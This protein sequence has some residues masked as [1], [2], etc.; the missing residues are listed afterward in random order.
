MLNSNQIVCPPDLLA[1]AKTLPPATGVI[2][3]ADNRLTLESVRMAVDEGLLV[4]ILVGAPKRIAAT[5]E[6]MAWDISSFRMVAAE[7]DA[8]VANR[9][10]ELAGHGESELLVKGHVHTDAF[11]MGII[12]RD[13]G[14]RV[15]RRLTHVFHM[16]VPGHGR[17]LMIADGAVNVAPSVGARME[18]MANA[19][20]LAHAL[21]IERPHVGVLSGTEEVT[22]KM[23]SSIDAAALAKRAAKELPSARVHGPLAFDI[24]VSREAAR[25]KGFDH[26]VAGDIDILLVPTIEVGNALFKMMVYFMG[27]CAAGVVMGAKVPAV[28]TSRADPP[29]ARLAS[30]ALASI[31]AHAKK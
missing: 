1:R 12:R 25:I 30:I 3:G 29:A 19:V 27:A 11:M 14:L 26:P 21:G 13:S 28:L 6:E 23:P 10:A 18:I 31:L 16:T 9:A 20:R 2:A 7:G 8:E 4:P 17:A 22:D 15:G 5:A 24:A